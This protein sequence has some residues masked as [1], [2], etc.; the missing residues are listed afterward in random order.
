MIPVFMGVEN[1]GNVPTIVLR[2]PETLDVIQRIDR[3]RLTCFGTHHQI[4]E[5][6]PIVGGP[7]LLDNHDT[8]LWA[9]YT[10]STIIYARLNTF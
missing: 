2:F 8:L 5:V 10:D 4:I 7:D 3:Q 1:L 9:C 6:T